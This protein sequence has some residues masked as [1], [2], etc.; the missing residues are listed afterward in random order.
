MTSRRY[1]PPHHRACALVAEQD[2]FSSRLIA[3]DISVLDERI[4]EDRKSLVN[5]LGDILWAPMR[6][7]LR[8]E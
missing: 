2:V 4:L 5:L 8:L 6:S 3:L 7:F 1:L